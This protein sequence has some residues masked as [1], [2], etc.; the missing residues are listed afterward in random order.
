MSGIYF[1]IPYCQHACTYCNFHFS[2][3]LKTKPAVLDAMKKELEI[4]SASWTEPLSTIYFGGGTPSILSPSEFSD[5]IESVEADFDI[6]SVK[7]FT[8]ECNPEDLVEEKLKAW[9]DAGVN[10]LSIGIQSFQDPILKIINR[11]H[12]AK[13]AID[14]VERARKY[15]FKNI[16]LDII[17]G[18]PGLSDDLLRKDLDQLLALDPEH[19]SVYQLTLEE[20]TQLAHQVKK[21]EIELLS[22]EAINRQYLLTHVVLSKEGFDHYEISNYSK[23]GFKA[24]H[25]SSYWKG[26]SYLGIGPGAH[27]FKDNERIWNVANNIGYVNAFEKNEPWYEGEKLESKDQ[28]NEFIMISLRTKEGLNLREL[29]AKFPSNSNN[30]RNTIDLWIENELAVYDND[31]VKLSLK[32]WL[33]SD[34]LASDLFVI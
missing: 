20:K 8:I 16:S 5:L 10:R 25:N 9:K 27:S 19:I 29:E 12:T 2:T 13:E 3:S 1:H 24:V 7:E 30:V 6:S 21:G 17:L 4:R 23:P 31:S 15:M 33:I 26:T 32:G 14:G 11:H 34:D 22:D 18:L 28:F